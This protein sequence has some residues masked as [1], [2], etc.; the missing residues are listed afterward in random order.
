MF[1]EISWYSWKDKLYRFCSQPKSTNRQIIPNLTKRP[2]IHPLAF[3]W[4][5]TASNIDDSAAN[6]SINF[7]AEEVLL[8]PELRR[9]LMPNHVAVRMDWDRRW[10]KIR[11]LPVALGYE[12]GIWALR[13]PVELCC[14]WGISALSVFAFPLKI[15]FVIK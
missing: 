13:N 9:E 5:D 3:A 11:G 8:P 10:A 15:G 2:S 4:N 7:S 1:L 14:N 12:A 6:S